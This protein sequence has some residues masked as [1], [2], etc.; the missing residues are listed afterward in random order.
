VRS[1]G[2]RWTNGDAVEPI[3]ASEWANLWFDSDG[4][5]FRS[6]D[7]WSGTIKWQHAWTDVSFRHDDLTVHWPLTGASSF[8]K[9]LADQRRD[10]AARRREWR[11]QWIERFVDRQRAARR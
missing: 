9:M 3:P 6:Y 10:R 8:L 5:R 1:R 7:L 11:Q 4:Q 2:R